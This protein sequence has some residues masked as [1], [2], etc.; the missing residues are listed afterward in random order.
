MQIS[1]CRLNN[2]SRDNAASVRTGPAPAAEAEAASSG[3]M[4]RIASIDVVG[5]AKIVPAPGP[6]LP[7][8]SRTL[9][10]P[11]FTSPPSSL[12]LRQVCPLPHK[13]I[14]LMAEVFS[15]AV[16]ALV[17]WR[18]C[19]MSVHL[20]HARKTLCPT[21]MHSAVLPGSA[22]FALPLREIG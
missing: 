1:V 13:Q 8:P 14:S 22:Y 19:D 5:P 21:K 3:N 17:G 4:G 2:V 9:S 6:R 11:P 20:H 12:Y 7:T 16:C 15:E 18:G 10:P